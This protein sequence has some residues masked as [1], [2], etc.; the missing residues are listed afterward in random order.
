[1]SKISQ[2]SGYTRRERRSLTLF[3]KAYFQK[4]KSQGGIES[5]KNLKKF[6]AVLVVLTLMVSSIVVPVSA[7]ESIKYS[8]EAQKLYD[9]GLYKGISTEVFNPDPLQH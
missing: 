4:Q 8:D 2:R 3:N 6:F 9:L 5:M 1:L 7:A